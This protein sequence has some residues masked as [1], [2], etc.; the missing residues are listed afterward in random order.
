MILILEILMLVN[1]IYMLCTGRLMGKG[2]IS[3]KQVRWLGGMLLLPIPV[4][5]VVSILIGIAV[6]ISSGSA[7][8]DSDTMKWIGIGIEVGTVLLF[9][10][11]WALWEKS[12]RKKVAQSEAARNCAAC[13]YSLAALPI[14]CNCP[15]CGRPEVPPRLA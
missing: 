2:R 3:H 9:A 7:A 12:I 11:A 6:A 5:L 8:L 1:G 13:G 14:G 15:E 10:L 4:V